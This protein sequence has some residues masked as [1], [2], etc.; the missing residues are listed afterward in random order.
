MGRKILANTFSL[1]MLSELLKDVLTSVD[2]KVTHIS[3]AD[4]PVDCESLWSNID[5]ARLAS[6]RLGWNVLVCQRNDSLTRGDT[7]YMRQYVN[8]WR[9][10]PEGAEIRF[11]KVEIL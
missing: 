1:N 6:D 3:S 2:I 4:V 11:L 8:P 10:D 5:S 9:P 7:L